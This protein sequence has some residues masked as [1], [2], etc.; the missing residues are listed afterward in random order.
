M[1]SMNY[2]EENEA[3]APGEGDE[4]DFVT[5]VMN[6][7]RRGK[8]HWAK[9][10]LAA[11]DDYDFF[12]GVQWDETDSSKLESEGRPAVVFN[13]IVRTINS[14]SGLEIQNR[15]EVKY[16]PRKMQSS[17]QNPQGT[18]DAGYSDMLNGASKWVR[19]QNDAE[20]EESEAFQDSLICG[21]GWT[22]TR[23]DYERDPQGM[24]VKDRIDPLEMMA[25]PDSRKKNFADAKWIS[26]IRDYTRKEIREMFPR[27][28]I[29][30][31]TPGTF[32]NVD[33][34]SPH[35]AQDAW[36]Y[37]N[38]Q[39][40]RLTEVG[41]M[42]VV[43]YQYYV[44]EQHYVLLTPDQNI[45]TFDQKRYDAAKPLIDR[46]RVKVV[47]IKK[48]VYKQCFLIGNRIAD[49][50]D[51]GCDHFTFEGITGLR[52]R[53]RNLWFGLVQLMKDP[54]RWANKWMSQI[55]YI[56]NTSSKNAMLVEAGAV[57]NR[58]ALEDDLAQPGAI[59]DLNPGGLAKIREMDRTSY[60]DGIDRLLQYAISAI[61]DVPGVNLELVGMADRD[62]PMGLENMRKQAGITV[63]ATFFD[64]LRR[65]RKTDGRVLAYFIR[66]Y[67]ADGRLVRIL[68]PDGAR[69]VPLIKDKVSF[70]YD[71]IVDDSPTSPNS[72]ERTFMIMNQIA[73]MLM[74]AG[75]PIPPEILDY[76]PLPEDFIQKWKQLINSGNQPDPVQEELRQIQLLMAK[77]AP[78]KEQAS[79]QKI[80]SETAKNYATAE[81]EK[82]VGQ[83]QSALAMQK[84]GVLQN[85]HALKDM[86]MQRTQERKDLEL[87][88]NHYRRMLEMQL[89]AELKSKYMGAAPSLNTIQ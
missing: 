37:R 18:N 32:W 16:F 17:D 55:Q 75:I 28:D 36:M 19:D 7:L 40:P 12:A 64:S 39:S 60:P 54:Q 61:N 71:V 20:D 45:I 65:Y 27:F 46:Q 8:S 23:M 30:A 47:K 66:E 67:I 76:A 9:W 59:I 57:T 44:K 21:V 25:D 53:N 29:D 4:D 26:C 49:R 15:Q 87:T 81:K 82:S 51:L 78:L 33:D 62:Q 1:T 58:R 52:D 41:K 69:Y 24:I 83:E 84:F 10:R 3:S 73:P 2:Q 86:E 70:E 72:K 79:I 74:Q 85:D 38:D 35:D 6:N 48:R 89:E 13:R 5:E 80:G 56:L 88:L 31:T 77:L 68:G 11:R 43:Q 50:N 22:E 14:V 34:E 42:S 63:L